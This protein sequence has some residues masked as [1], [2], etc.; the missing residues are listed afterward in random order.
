MTDCIPLAKGKL[1]DPLL[2]EWA[3][4]RHRNA[5]A[6]VAER[7]EAMEQTWFDDLTLRRWL[8]SGDHETLA[9]LFSQ[10]PAERFSNLGQAIAE[11]WGQ[12]RGN[13]AYHAAPVLAR[14][15]PDLA[16]KCFAQPEC[17]RHPDAYA[18]L[19]IVR[20]LPFLPPEAGRT[21]LGAIA[22]EA[23][24]TQHE[25]IERD[26]VLSE[27]IS[28]G[29][30]IDRSMVQELIGER[31]K[32]GTNERALDDILN[33]V[34]FGLFGINPYQGLASDIRKGETRQRFQ[35]LAALFQDDAPLGRLDQ[36]SQ[37]QVT[38]NDLTELVHAFLEEDDRN[39]ILAVV[40]T[41]KA[42][43]IAKHWDKVADFLI[44][45]IA[46]ACA[47]DDLDT[48]AMGLQEVVGLLSADL[49]SLPPEN[50]LV[51]RLTAF[52]PDA[53]AALL[54]ETLERE[55]ATYGAVTLAGIM[56]RLGSETFLPPLTDAMSDESGDLLCEAARDALVR[57]G[58]PARDHLIERWDRLDGAQRIYGLSVIVAVG[59]EP[60]A[61]FALDRYDDLLSEDPESWCRLAAAAPDRRLV[62]RLERQLPRHQGLFDETFYLL[63]RL[64]DLDHPQLDAVDQRVRKRRAEQQARRAAFERGDWFQETLNLGL[65]CPVCGDVNDYAVRR[66]AIDPAQPG[67]TP[68]LAQELACASC[69][70]W[71]DLELT[72]EAT[73][74]VT[75][76]LVKSAA[77]LGAGLA[78]KS[79]VLTRAVAPLNG[80]M[81]PVGEVVAHC[82]AAVATNP[83]RV[84]DWVRLAYCF[85]QVLARPRFGAHY[86]DQA[87]SLEANAVEAVILKADALT[88]A[89]HD[90][91]AFE[92]LDH[93]L[94]S[95]ERWRFFLTD[96]STPAQIAA[97]FA[98]FYNDLLRR[99]GRTDR[100]SLH[101]SFLGASQK[102]GRNDPCPCGSGRKY[103]KC[104]LQRS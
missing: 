57:I 6:G 96:V 72:N 18:T 87:L 92:L 10:L 69:G 80:G 27:L 103:K 4:R 55:K 49:S 47:R 31:L 2:M 99:L 19:G 48:S 88:V 33:R 66:L 7:Q 9:R 77:D 14:H 63:A 15:A 36:W 53:V 58:E 74:A 73:L 89:G 91:Q 86:T 65:R 98:G 78:G 34:A 42:K 71:S 83:G 32:D 45:A 60:V 8:D 37:G 82:R 56:G 67:R 94:A 93:A 50:A 104:C 62:D 5:Q 35:A 20:A 84:G 21:L 90:E 12:W 26:L 59:G 17:K 61:A 1:N 68:L 102:V 46:A 101:A 70:Q 81:R 75:A 29:L 39:V 3:L 79:K 52:E 24:A 85:H 28:V 25:G 38:L 41:L 40:E 13:L 97:Q 23:R 30:K 16:W 95:K 43:G 22:K 11:R 76:E 100:A 44:G 64:L 51:A 54:V